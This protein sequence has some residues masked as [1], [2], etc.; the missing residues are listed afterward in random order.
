MSPNASSAQAIVGQ[1]TPY[2]VAKVTSGQY[3]TCALFSNGRIKCWGNN[4]YGQLGYGESSDRG[5]NANEMGANLTY[6]DLGRSSTSALLAIDV[7][8]G[9]SHV[10]ALMGD[11]RVKCWGININGALGYGDTTNRGALPSEMGNY[12][13]IVD[14]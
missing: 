12:L 14:L 8:A 7:Q 1:S 2:T 11:R 10:C 6:V 4:Q 13:P 3:F 9:L 5:D